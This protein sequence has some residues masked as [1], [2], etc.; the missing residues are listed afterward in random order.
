MRIKSNYKAKPISYGAKRG[1]KSVKKIYIH[2]TANDGDTAENNA[3]FYATGNKREAGAHIFIDRK[4]NI[5][6]SINLNRVAYS[7][8]NK[9]EN[10]VSVSIE[11]CD[12]VKHLPSSEQLEALF[13]TVRWIKKYCPNIKTVARHYDASGKDCPKP[14]CGN[15]VNDGRWE[16][17]KSA[18][19]SLL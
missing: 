19:E 8:G 4:G 18:L 3:K 1:Y 13:Y 2:W 6:K 9:Q 12:L 14:F 11:L 7:V 15:R 16:V 17:L 5:Y 10:T